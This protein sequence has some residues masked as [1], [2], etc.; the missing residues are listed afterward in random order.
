MENCHEAGQTY[1]ICP[2]NYSAT[3][4][5]VKWGIDGDIINTGV[6]RYSSLN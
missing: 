4:I 2:E 3:S 5:E 1:S 6:A